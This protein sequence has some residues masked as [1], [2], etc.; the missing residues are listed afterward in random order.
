MEM[1]QSGSNQKTIKFFS[2]S[3]LAV[4]IL[5][6]GLKLYRSPVDTYTW[7]ELL[8]NYEAGFIRRGLIGRIGYLISPYIS[9]KFFLSAGITLCYLLHLILYV[10]LTRAIRLSDWLLF[11]FSPAA[12]LFPIYDFDAFGRKDV[13]LILIFMLS[14]WLIL[15]RL[16]LKLLVPIVLIL[17]QIGTLIH[18]YALFYFPFCV[19]LIL[20]VYR[21]RAGK[22][23]LALLICSAIFLVGNLIWLYALSR[24]YYNLDL[25]PQSWEGLIANYNLTPQSGAFGWLGVPLKEGLQPVFD[26]LSYPQTFFSYLAAMLLSFIPMLVLN[27]RYRIVQSVYAHYRGQT[28]LLVLFTLLLL[29]TLPI[30][31]FSSDWGRL[32][33]LFG[34]NIFLSLAVLKESFGLTEEPNAQERT[35][36]SK[37]EWAVLFILFA[38]TWFV[39]MYVDGGNIALQQGL[40]FKILDWISI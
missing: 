14:F 9:V 29:G 37:L 20:I 11:T 27:A 39:K 5:Y 40:I 24:Q 32:I 18:E 17:Y 34:F 3:I 33:Y 13:F 38:G 15:Q 16:R 31:I 4:L 25:I 19:L 22:E 7:T 23:L 10:N 12:F 8:I 6:F 30:F 35:A 1:S 21:E 28:L 36:V 26:K 2:L